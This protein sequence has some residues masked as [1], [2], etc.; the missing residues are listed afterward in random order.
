M[1]SN[2]APV[3]PWVH[4]LPLFVL[5]PGAW[6]GRPLSVVEWCVH[7]AFCNS[8]CVPSPL[9]TCRV[10]RSFDSQA[11]IFLFHPFVLRVLCRGQ[12]ALARPSMVWV[13]H[14]RLP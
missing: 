12:V 6:T 3:P 9:C 7:A 1:W 2:V 10:P 13:T 11:V 14:S 5:Y 8:L 4:V